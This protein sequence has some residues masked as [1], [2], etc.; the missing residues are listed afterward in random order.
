MLRG[1]VGSICFARFREDD[2]VAESIKKTAQQNN[3]KAGAVIVIGALK[4]AVLGCYKD[5]EYVN[6]EL[7]GHFEIASCTGNLAVDEKGDTIVHVHIVVSNENGQAF[8]GHLQKGC[9]I[10]PTAELVIIEATGINLQRTFDERTKLKLL[11]LS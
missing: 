3:V 9:L 2:D 5:G 1:S 7:K 10:G 8:G 4:Q 11:K 6:T